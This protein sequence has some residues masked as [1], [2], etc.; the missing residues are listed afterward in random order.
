[1]K[2]KILYHMVKKVKASLK[3]GGAERRPNTGGD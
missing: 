3:S 2:Y 1:M